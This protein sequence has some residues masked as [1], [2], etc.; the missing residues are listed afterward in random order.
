MAGKKTLSREEVLHVAKLANLRLSDAEVAKFQSQLG[1]I[2]DYVSQVGAVVGKKVPVGSMSGLENVLRQDKPAPSLSQADAIGNAPDRQ[3]GF[4]KT[5]LV[6]K[7][8]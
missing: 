8:S 5:K 2:L 7:E 6:L 1:E 3:N 4:I